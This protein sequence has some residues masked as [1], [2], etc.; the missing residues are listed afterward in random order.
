MKF[1]FQNIFF[2]FLLIWLIKQKRIDEVNHHKHHHQHKS[3][4]NHQILHPNDLLAQPVPNGLAVGHEGVEEG[5]VQVGDVHER[6][7]WEHPVAGPV[8]VA[9]QCGL[10]GLANLCD[11]EHSLLNNANYICNCAE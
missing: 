8:D 11:R 4:G 9:G 6:A 2:V 1:H 5:H 10:K 7:V 3:H